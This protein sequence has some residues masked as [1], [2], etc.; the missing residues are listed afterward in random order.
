MNAIASTARYDAFFA[1]R[2]AAV[3]RLSPARTSPVANK[4][5]TSTPRPV[6]P[7]VAAQSVKGPV[8]GRFVDFIA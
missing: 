7:V 1:T 3:Q 8:K 4:P 6:D 5:L 2:E